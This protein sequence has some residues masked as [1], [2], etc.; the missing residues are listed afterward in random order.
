M[1]LLDD[2]LLD[3]FSESQSALQTVNNNSLGFC[4]KAEVKS[5]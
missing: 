1:S 4:R 2:M 5:I 3:S